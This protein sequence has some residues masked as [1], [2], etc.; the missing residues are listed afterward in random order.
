MDIEG[1]EMQLLEDVSVIPKTVDCF[2]VEYHLN[3]LGY[4]VRAKAIHQ[5]FVRNGWIIRKM[6]SFTDKAWMAFGVYNR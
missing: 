1:A 2:A 3:P 4:R 5:D 6:P